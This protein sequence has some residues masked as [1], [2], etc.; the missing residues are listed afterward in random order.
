[1]RNQE[2]ISGIGLFLISFLG[3]V[4]SIMF[5]GVNYGIDEDLRVVLLIGSIVFSFPLGLFAMKNAYSLT[6]FIGFYIVFFLGI[7]TCITPEL[8]IIFGVIV[9]YAI[10]LVAYWR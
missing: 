1:M 2:I 9:C 5:L 4:I 8:S 3:L 6:G 10:A 7:L